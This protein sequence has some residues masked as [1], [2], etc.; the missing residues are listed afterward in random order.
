M[1]LSVSVLV[2]VSACVLVSASALVFVVVSALALVLV[3][4]LLFVLTAAF[5]A[6]PVSVLRSVIMLLLSTAN[7]LAASSFSVRSSVSV[8]PLL[9]LSAF[10]SSQSTRLPQRSSTA[11][12]GAACNGRVCWLVCLFVGWVV[13]WLAG[14]LAGLVA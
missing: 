10:R 13:S 8:S 6:K 11:R 4:I 9:P 3:V 12:K 1:L 14:W 2:Q 7:C 5:I